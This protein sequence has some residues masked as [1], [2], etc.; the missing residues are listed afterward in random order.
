MGASTILLSL[1]TPILFLILMFGVVT[2]IG[3][4]GA[5]VNSAVALLDR[6]FRRRTIALGLVTAGLS[7]GGLVMVPR[8]CHIL[9]QKTRQEELKTGF[10]SWYS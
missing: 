4:A 7:G 6:L 8:L 10:A 9:T 2:A 1:T 3:A 5:G